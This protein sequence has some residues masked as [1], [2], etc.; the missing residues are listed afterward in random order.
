MTNG[1]TQEGVIWKI[2]KYSII[3]LPYPVTTNPM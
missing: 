1:T 3:I 2:N